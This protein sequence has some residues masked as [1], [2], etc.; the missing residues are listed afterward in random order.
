MEGFCCDGG[1]PSCREG[2]G[3]DGPFD[4]SED[5]S[6][7]TGSTEELI[8]VGWE[9]EEVSKADWDASATGMF[10]AHKYVLLN[11]IKSFWV[12]G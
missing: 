8:V 9:P 7:F 12:I 5:D 1:C 2:P 3:P 11:K 4:F 10:S 6:G